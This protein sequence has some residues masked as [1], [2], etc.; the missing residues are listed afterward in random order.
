MSTKMLY[1]GARAAGP[2]GMSYIR[3]GRASANGTMSLTDS[4]SNYP[5]I[6]IAT[7]YSSEYA[8]F[9]MLPTTIFEN[10]TMPIHI[11]FDA[12]GTYHHI[13]VAYATDTTVTVSNRAS[14]N[15]DI[16]GVKI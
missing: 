11:R 12:S 7:Y 15:V 4:L 8:T 13:Q 16:Y 5:F 3:L 6:V 10:T 2:G 9:D 14:L 1:G